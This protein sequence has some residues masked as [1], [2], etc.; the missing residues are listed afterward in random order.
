[1]SDPVIQLLRDMDK[2]LD[3]ALEVGAKNS[4]DLAWVKRILAG[5]GVVIGGAF[6]HVLHKLGLG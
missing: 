4:A 1:M 5:A 6:A 2:K 3:R